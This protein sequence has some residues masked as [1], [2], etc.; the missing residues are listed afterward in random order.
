MSQESVMNL[1]SSDTRHYTNVARRLI[2][3]YVSNMQKYVM[4]TSDYGYRTFMPKQKED[5][6]EVPAKLTLSTIEGHLAGKYTVAVYASPFSSRF[7]CFDIDSRDE[8]A[9]RKVISQLVCW[10]IPEEKVYVSDSGNKG[11]HVE[12]FFT[13]SV[14]T[15]D[16][17]VLYEDVIEKQALDRKKVEFRPTAGQ[18]IK[19]PLGIHQKTKRRCWFLNRGTLESIED[20]GYIFQIERVDPTEIEKRALNHLL[21]KKFGSVGKTRDSPLSWKVDLSK[22]MV[23]RHGEFN[24][25]IVALAIALRRNTA[26]YTLEQAQS[27][28]ERWYREQDEALVSEAGT[29]ALNHLMRALK[30]AWAKLPPVQVDAGIN[31]KKQSPITFTK[32]ELWKALRLKTVSE[33]RLMFLMMCICKRHEVCHCSAE[34]LASHIGKTPRMVTNVISKLITEGQIEKTYAGGLRL[35]NGNLIRESNEYC[36]VWGD[37]DTVGIRFRREEIE[38]SWFTNESFLK[39]YYETL[40]EAVERKELKKLLTAKEKAYIKKELGQDV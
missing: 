9:V 20:T 2:W 5:G 4:S 3:L 35:V 38:V 33:R 25:K 40:L 27:I 34:Y 7:I 21:G 13:K 8:Q 12:V 15:A 6:R 31:E 28:A 37:L 17:K 30:W 10:G 19:L 14:F 26:G 29:E 23:E 39:V 1:S 32:E 36:V 24:E 11:F 22:V 18:S 16:L